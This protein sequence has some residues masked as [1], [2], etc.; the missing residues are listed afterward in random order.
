MESV[1][2]SICRRGASMALPSRLGGLTASNAHG[3]ALP[4]TIR[5]EPGRLST[6]HI[7]K[8]LTT[9]LHMPFLRGSNNY[10]RFL[11]LLMQGKSLPHSMPEMSQKKGSY[12]TWLR[13][14]WAPILGFFK[15]RKKGGQ[16]FDPGRR[17]SHRN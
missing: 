16:D 1:K 3:L 6:Q 7:V 12:M 5:P 15:E 10:Y 4:G 17:S 8:S 2:Q 14:G 13:R 9:A 11:A